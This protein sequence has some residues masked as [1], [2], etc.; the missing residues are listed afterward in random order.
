VREQ[1]RRRIVQQTG[2]QMPGELH[3]QLKKNSGHT[4]RVHNHDTLTGKLLATASNEDQPSHPGK[5]P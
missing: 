4:P 2:R 5:K 3:P 1:L